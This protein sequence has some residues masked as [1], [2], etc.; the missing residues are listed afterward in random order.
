MTFLA[1]KTALLLAG[2]AVPLLLLLYFL[3][4][5]RREHTVSSTLLWKRAVHDLQVNAPFQRLRSSLLLLLQLL[6][7]AAVL[8]ALAHPVADF[9]EKPPQNIVLLIDR[10]ASMKTLEPD[11][12]PRLAHAKDAALDRVAGLPE[13]S[14]AMVISFADRAAVVSTFTDDR[15]RL[16]RLI[17]D[18]EPT[19]APSRIG[20][21]L[22]LAVAYSVHAVGEHGPD[23]S[24]AVAPAGGDAAGGGPA[25]AAAAAG[26]AQAEVEVYSDGR[27][28]DVPEETAVPIVLRYIRVGAASD[29]VGLVGF[30]LRRDFEQPGLLA[31]MAQVRNFGPE[32]VAA[33]LSLSIDG[34][35]ISGPGGVREVRLAPAAADSSVRPPAASDPPTAETVLFEIIHEGGGVLEVRWHRED[36]LAADNLIVAPI[37]PPREPRVLVVSDR[38]AVRAL[39]LRGLASVGVS[40]V[41]ALSG[42]EYAAVPEGRLTRDGRLAFDLAVLDRID[43]DRLPPGDYLFFGGLPRVDGVARGELVEDQPVVAWREDH[44]LVRWV[45]FEGVYVARWSRLTL[46]EGALALA[47]GE[48]SVVLALLTD[49][50]HRYLL[51][52]FDL[53]DTDLLSRPAWP[54]F[55][56]NVV[57][58]AVGAGLVEAARRV[59]PGD[60]LTVPV[61][62]GATRARVYRPDGATD[63]LE[64]ADRQSIPYARTQ[65]VGFYRVVFDDPAGTEERFAANLLS[66]VESWVAPSEALA[67][68]GRAVEPFTGVVRVNR[69]LWP[70]LA[71]AGL[72]LLMAEWWVYHR[73]VMI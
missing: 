27:L 58:A 46:P 2:V 3:K 12:R 64:V 33:D 69:P 21:A 50:G 73:R 71:G 10:S 54:I 6:F 42:E 59:T 37:D 41:E 72:L 14:R 7:L 17:E 67:V 65:E 26:A 53:A 35:P 5:R 23:G 43:T 48:D 11:G 62:P 18:I 68:G 28:E 34:T 9:L 30:G 22:Q 25:G 19:D 70:W 49:P 40:R 47:E 4:L 32:A 45:P 55:L 61:P 31:V 60:T 16:R 63:T 66:P 36:A 38:P 51:A 1:W 52:A 29:N 57:T 15:R 56:Q 24:A 44:P 20:E 8:F 39:L 13:K